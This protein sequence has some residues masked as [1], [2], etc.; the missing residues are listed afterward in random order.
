MYFRITLMR[1]KV[2]LAR[3]A[4]NRHWLGSHAPIAAR[5]PGLRSY[6]QNHILSIA[7]PFG[8]AAVP[9]RDNWLATLDGIARLSFDSEEEMQ[10]AFGSPVMLEIADDT[11]LYVSSIQA[12]GALENVVIGPLARGG[13]CKIVSLHTRNPSLDE[14][15]FQEAWRARYAGLVRELSEC[16]GYV[17]SRIVN[18]SQAGGLA[19]SYDELP[20][21][22]V[23]EIYFPSEDSILR[24]KSTAQYAELSRFLQSI[25]REVM[26]FS[27]RHESI[28]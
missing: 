28:V 20:F 4:F 8:M 11:P 15:E 5:L 25:S 24:V 14:A 6:V 3:D 23:D 27:V 1:R 26:S 16:A 9:S 10:T 7:P 13:A 12:F 17:Q 18:R 2:G 19:A 21:D 22:G